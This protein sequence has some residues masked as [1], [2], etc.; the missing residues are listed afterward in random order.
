MYPACNHWFPGA[1][2]PSEGLLFHQPTIDPFIV[3]AAVELL[4]LDK[5]QTVVEVVQGMRMV[6]ALKSPSQLTL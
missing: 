2:A 1:L 6:I 3:L 4:V 5:D